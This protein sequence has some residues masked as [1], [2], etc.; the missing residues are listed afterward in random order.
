MQVLVNDIS[1]VLH[2][3]IFS[4]CKKICLEVSEYIF[5]KERKKN[6]YTDIKKGMY[7][8]SAEHKVVEGIYN[9]IF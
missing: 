1:K 4:Q 7:L 8:I 3:G 5:K 9:I 6:K 2:T